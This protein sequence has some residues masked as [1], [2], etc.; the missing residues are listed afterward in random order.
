MPHTDNSSSLPDV[1]GSLRR[2][3]VDILATGYLRLRQRRAGLEIATFSEKRL[4]DVRDSARFGTTENRTLEK[5][6]PT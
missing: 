1:P 6:E 3:V 4:D 5:G 2:E